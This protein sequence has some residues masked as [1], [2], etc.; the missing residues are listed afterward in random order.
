M[1]KRKVQVVI[2]YNDEN[3]IKQFLLLKVN[4]ERGLF[5]QNVTGSVDEG[6]DFKQAAIREAMEET[7]LKTENL[8]Q[9]YQSQLC[10]NFTDRWEKEVTEQVFFFHC[11]EKWNVTLDPNEHCE[12]NWVSEENINQHSVKYET[13]HL[14]LKAAMDMS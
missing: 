14:A 7:D 6:E 3:A 11:K 13:N 10:F 2:Y 5:W 12:F 9:I 4:Q 8:N 1:K